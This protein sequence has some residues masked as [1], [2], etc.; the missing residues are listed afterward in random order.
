MEEKLKEVNAV[1][2]KV[3]C[4]PMPP[5]MA[6]CYIVKA[7]NGDAFAVDPGSYGRRLE[8]ALSDEGITELK[9]I[10]LTH[11]HYDHIMGAEKLRKSYG[12]KICVHTLDAPCLKNTEKSRALFRELL[13]PPFDYD[14]LLN[15]GDSLSFGG[16]EIEVI[17]TPGHTVGSVCY[18]YGSCLFTGDTLF[19][20][21][22]G[23][24]DF[25]GG[26]EKDMMSSMKK[27]KALE[28][29]YKV[30]PGH[31]EGSTLDFERAYNPYM[32]GI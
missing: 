18:K 31:E 13:L 3:R 25:E 28:G 21:C 10:L 1:N 2:F 15:D 20:L 14:V 32:K 6:N 11:G 4:C 23:R 27:L 30:Y 12:G 19:R 29:D 5:L 9:Y 26:S 22:V 16:S 24:T 7:E 17:H 8:K